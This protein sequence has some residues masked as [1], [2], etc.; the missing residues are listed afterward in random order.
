MYNKMNHI[1]YGNVN[2]LVFPGIYIQRSLVSYY[3]A[4][5]TYSV[6]LEDQESDVTKNTDEI[7]IT[8]L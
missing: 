5:I 1:M 2:V 3:Q 4:L 7:D 6:S 8:F